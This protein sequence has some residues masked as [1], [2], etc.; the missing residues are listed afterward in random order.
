MPP[1]PSHALIVEFLCLPRAPFLRCARQVV[2]RGIALR[3]NLGL[4]QPTTASTLIHGLI[5]GVTYHFTVSCIAHV[6]GA[7]RE[8]PPSLMSKPLDIPSVEEEE[9]NMGEILDKVFAYGLNEEQATGAT[10]STGIAQ[11]GSMGVDSDGAPPAT[12][13][14]PGSGVGRRHSSSDSAASKESREPDSPVSPGSSAGLP[15]SSPLR[16]S[17][18][19]APPPAPPPSLGEPGTSAEAA[20]SPHAEG[21]TA[22]VTAGAHAGDRA[23]TGPADKSTARETVRETGAPPS[24]ATPATPSPATCEGPDAPP[25]LPLGVASSS[26]EPASPARTKP[27]DP[28]G[29]HDPHGA[30]DGDGAGDVASSAGAAGEVG[31][32]PAAWEEDRG[33]GR[34]DRREGSGGDGNGEGA[35]GSD[36]GDPSAAP[37]RCDRGGGGGSSEN[38]GVD[39]D[40]AGDRSENGDASP[41]PDNDPD[42][43][44]DCD[45][46]GAAGGVRP[47]GREA[48]VVASFW[49]ED[50]PAADEADEDGEVFGGGAAA[51][52]AA[53]RAA[54]AEQQRFY[55]EAAA[56][57]LRV[58]QIL[59]EMRSR[60][61]RGAGGDDSSGAAG[62]GAG[63]PGGVIGGVTGGLGSEALQGQRGAGSGE[64]GRDECAVS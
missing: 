29:P 44:P 21:V 12:A 30:G 59:F 18:R 51:T 57:K 33:V 23:S 3:Q 32:A 47:G 16:A 15:G 14:G 37:P 38:D 54:Q 2:D 34:E 9:W 26:S 62:P 27:C 17:H 58:E 56:E 64:N 19:A 10:G 48:L 28:L 43:D 55:Q 45:P 6:Q 35:G 39:D 24:D 13:A 40:E 52:A 53:R 5:P 11:W 8:S 60:Q 36:G 4:H 7:L 50:E 41:Q 1:H 61:Q 22:G 25:G 20:P 46:N 63:H 31:C 42:C 49:A